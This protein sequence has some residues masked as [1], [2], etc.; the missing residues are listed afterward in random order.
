M[1]QELLIALAI[2]IVAVI[3]YLS[4][5]A[6]Q[7]RQQALRAWAAGRG[8]SFR[9]AKDR[10][11]ADRFPEFRPL[12]RGRSRFARNIVSGTR[13]GHELTAFD[14]QYTTGHGKNRR[15][16]RF[17]VAVVRSPHPLIPLRIRRENVF[18]RVGEFL[19]FD[20]IDFESAEF[21]RRFH[22]GSPDRK[23]A[24]DVLHA[25]A[26][27]FMLRECFCNLEFDTEHVFAYRNRRFA[28]DEFARAIELAVGLLE[29]IPDYVVREMGG[30]TPRLTET[31]RE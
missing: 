31:E 1:P 19:G 14:Y 20:D 3:G 5:R 9:A 13:E 12:H 11:L 18:D 28:P 4:W 8:Y 29:R 16:H 21:S 30:P 2:L 15:T 26:I 25:R 7:K 24:Y 27:E 10:R 17:S 6:E 22:V 23:W